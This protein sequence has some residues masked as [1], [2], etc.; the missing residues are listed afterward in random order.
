MDDIPYRPAG[1]DG[2]HHAHSDPQQVLRV[3][4]PVDGDPYRNPLHDLHVVA[5]GVLRGEEG[6]A[7]PVPDMMLSTV[8]ANF[9]PG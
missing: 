2:R 4:L 7:A 8:P 5:R 6:E 1:D 3:A 9:L